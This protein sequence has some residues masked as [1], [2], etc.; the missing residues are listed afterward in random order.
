MDILSRELHLEVFQFAQKAQTLAAVL[1]EDDPV[2]RLPRVWDVL[3]DAPRC[4]RDE[5][6][7]VLAV[8]IRRM[9]EAFFDAERPRELSLDARLRRAHVRDVHAARAL[10]C[11]RREFSNAALDL[12]WTADRCHLSVSYLSHLLSVNTRYGFHAHLGA[13]RILHSARL[14]A[15]TPLSVEEVAD[16]SGFGSTAALDR[17]FRRRFDMT[18]SEFRRWG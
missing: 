2:R 18:P 11:I 4:D 9:A 13:I 5:D 10:E 6:R 17:E 16:K 14:L 8:I 12:R 7:V 3:C 1:M 15:T